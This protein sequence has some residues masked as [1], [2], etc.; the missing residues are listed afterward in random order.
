MGAS[1]DQNPDDTGQEHFFCQTMLLLV[2]A[3]SG[4][5]DLF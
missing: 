5:K 4:D 2:S 1:K 3:L